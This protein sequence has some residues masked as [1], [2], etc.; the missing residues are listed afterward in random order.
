M[1]ISVSRKIAWVAAAMAV[2]AAVAVRAD[3]ELDGA[4]GTNGVA[5]ISFPNST[6]GYLHSAQTLTDGTGTIELAGF[7]Q[8]NG[9]PT[10]AT[11]APNIFVARLS[12]D[13]SALSANSYPQAPAPAA[14]NGPG[15]VVIAP[16]T[17]DLFVV[18]SNVGSDGLLNAGA[19][20]LSSL[21]HLRS[22]YSRPATGLADQSACPNSR[23]ILD[24]RGRLVVACVYGDRS[25][26]LQ[27]AALRL[28]PRASFFKSATYN[29]IA[30]TS[31]GSNG[32]SIIATFPAG[33]SFAGATAITQDPN[34][35]AYYVAGFACAS[36]CLTA[37]ANQSVAQ[38]VARLNGTDG[39]L[40]TSYGNGGFA[41]AFQPMATGGNPDSIALDT[42]G[43]AL[44]SGNHSTP[45]SLTGTG[46]VARIAPSG[47]ADGGFGSG[48]VVQGVAGNEVVDVHTD[49]VNRVYALDHGTHLYRLNASGAPDAS[50]TSNTDVQTLNGAG[51]VWQSMQFV[52][53]NQQSA[54]L[55]GGVSSACSGSCATTAVIA[56]VTLITSAS[57]TS[58]TSSM[59]PSTI[60]MPVTFTATVTGT[61]PTGIVTIKDGATTLGTATLA[62]GS[63]TFT[64]SSLSVGQHGMTAIYGG[65]A[66][67]GPSS[68]PSLTQSV[69]ALMVLPTTTVLVVSPAT[70][71]VGQSVTL[72][73]TVTAVAGSTATGTVSF[74]DGATLVGTA[75][76][77][78]GGTATLTTSVLDAGSHA[79]TA[80]YT[81]DGTNG[82][83][84]SAAATVTVDLA[85]STAALTVAPA[86]TTVGQSV[87]LTATVTGAPGL[88][89]SGTV[90]FMDG[91]TAL[92]TGTLM[93]DGTATFS[94]AVLTV[95]N[96][97][98]T[99]SYG[100]DSNYS[101][102]TSPAATATVNATP[103]PVP[104]GG[105]G[106]G[107]GVGLVDLCALLSLVLARAFRPRVTERNSGRCRLG[108]RS[109]RA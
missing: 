70:V 52:D 76:L 18:G 100:G 65:D 62:G 81:G 101:P 72:T 53:I 32:F 4:F 57:T 63:A 33:F 69:N 77:A 47:M 24:N 59:N 20:W 91:T 96:H 27:L 89:P 86:T 15:G 82:P 13:G 58:V 55:V 36:N 10:S 42:S 14:L 95:G 11:P 106:G 45:G 83:S 105:G 51:S 80:D 1:K 31:F 104:S 37:T 84:A 5:K 102:S 64:T 79:I 35:G 9:L 60:G 17:G 88:T 41:V 66:N 21:G 108:T 67:N 73:A 43:N 71:T 85:V 29:L 30:D 54:Y 46:Y 103:P 38:L 87:T 109:H 97:S 74:T 16:F 39:K 56:K 3:G 90:S 7:E 78:A 8:A 99:V 75:A 40:D 98:L 26:T 48:G 34:S 44:I 19:V 28:I 107:G 93:A 22:H 68:S 92:G 49:A 2:F 25:G 6:H 61:S 23:P 50:F 12:A 94:T